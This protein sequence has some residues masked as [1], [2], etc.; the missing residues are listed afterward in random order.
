MKG[1]S[2]TYLK[3]LKVGQKVAFLESELNTMRVH[4]HKYG[5]SVRVRPCITRKNK[6]VA[7]VIKK[8]ENHV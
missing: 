3:K 6:L 4:F 5:L 1:K 2:R 7:W 8:K